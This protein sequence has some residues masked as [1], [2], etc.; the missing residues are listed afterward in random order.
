MIELSELSIARMQRGQLDTA[1]IPSVT[2]RKF[3]LQQQV[4]ALVARGMSLR[5]VARHLGVHRI[6][7]YK[8]LRG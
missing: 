3:L 7:L 5:A 4:E 8:R 2:E 6:V 1:M